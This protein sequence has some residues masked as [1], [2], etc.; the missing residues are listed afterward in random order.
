MPLIYVIILTWNQYHHTKACLESL[1]ETTYPNLRILVVDN[2][3]S[4]GTPAHVR[5]DFPAVTVL[6]NDENIG[7]AAGNNVGI[8]YALAEGADYVFVL[9]NDTLVAA[10]LFERLMDV[11]QAA[12]ARE[13]KLGMVAP[14]IYFAED[15][16]R[17]WS[18]GGKRHLLTY[19][20]RGDLHGQLD[21]GQLDQG[22]SDDGQPPNMVS[23][24]YFT[25]CALLLS[26]DL[27]TEVGPFDERFFFTYEDSDLCFRAREAGYQLLLAPQAHI[28]HKVSVSTGGSGSP[29]ER[30]WMARSS[31]LFFAK[32]VRG[33][34]WLVVVPYRAAS[35]LRTST[36]LLRQGKVDSLR[37]YWRGLREGVVEAFGAASHG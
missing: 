11:A 5:R 20:K 12:P 28:W 30:Y 23:Q 15:P 4:D 10:D 1:G 14:L 33:W 34:R 26:R 36:R 6:A 35:A 29:S 19:E 27:L 22:R 37:S 24:D 16:T 7:F 9:N 13:S 17:I 8:H 18:S 2:D 25:G 21:Q 3:S 31:V 32:H